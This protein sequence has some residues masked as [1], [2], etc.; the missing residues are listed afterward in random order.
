MT[1]VQPTQ[2]A[3]RDKDTLVIH[4]SD[5][6]QRIYDITALRL[7]C[8]CATCNTE[9]ERAGLEQSQPLS[10]SA[11]VALEQMTPIGNY[12]YHLRFSDGHDTGIYTLQLLRSLGEEAE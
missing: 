4:W 3:L 8:P 7:R 9:R 6:Q 5:G 12:A 10:Q 11:Q 2:L 1:T